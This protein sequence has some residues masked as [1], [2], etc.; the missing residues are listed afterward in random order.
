[1]IVPRHIDGNGRWAKARMMPKKLGHYKGAEV[2]E[3]VIYHCKKIG[4]EYVTLYA[5]SIENW[6]R[7]EEEVSDLMGLLREYLNKQVKN[8]V[9]NEIKLMFIGDRSLLSADIRSTMQELEEKSSKH[10]FTL[11]IAISYGSRN[12]ITNAAKSMALYVRENNIDEINE[13]FFEQ[14]IN[15]K[16]IPDPDLLIRTS[17]ELRISNFLLWQLAYS[18]LYFTSKL[19]P[20]VSE[21]DIDIAIEDF[22]KRD[23]RYGK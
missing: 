9:E 15:P 5:F 11:I 18:E 1:M 17:G 21:H 13:D 3:K 19:W 2:A 23:R 14:F 6:K 7:S 8:L 12:E 22:N 10:S 16:S 20:D 4:V